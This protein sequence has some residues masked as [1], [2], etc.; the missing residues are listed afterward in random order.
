MGSKFYPQEWIT[1][2]SGD[3]L[4]VG[5]IIGA[6]SIS[7]GSTWD[8]AVT[9]GEVENGEIHTVAEKDVKLVLRDGSWKDL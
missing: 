1:Y 4:M 8:Y 6:A 2:K 9:R 5:Q 7:A 3:G